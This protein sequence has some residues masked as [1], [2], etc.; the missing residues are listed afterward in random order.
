MP[1]ALARQA[2]PRP[3]AALR[4]LDLEATAAEV[5]AAL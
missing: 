5:L 3:F 1:N 2:L 4:A